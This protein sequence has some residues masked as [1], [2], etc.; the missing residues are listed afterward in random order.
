MQEHRHG[1]SELAVVVS[2]QA[3]RELIFFRKSKI[4]GKSTIPFYEQVLLNFVIRAKLF[5]ALLFGAFLLLNFLM[6][7]PI[8]GN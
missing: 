3:D 6:L 7:C 8:A 2:F 5:Y 1:L 4:F